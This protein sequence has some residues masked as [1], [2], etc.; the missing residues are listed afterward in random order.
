MKGITGL[1]HMF[2]PVSVREEAKSSKADLSLQCRSTVCYRAFPVG[3][4]AA[5]FF[6]PFFLFFY[7]GSPPRSTTACE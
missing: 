7:L 2:R 6:F 4:F 5:N 1:T 3:A